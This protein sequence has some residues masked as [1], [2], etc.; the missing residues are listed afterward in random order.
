MLPWKPAPEGGHR[1]ADKEQTGATRG[2]RDEG[3]NGRRR[4][5][6]DQHHRSRLASVAQHG[7]RDSGD[8]GQHEH[9]QA[10][11][12][13]GVAVGQRNGAGPSAP[14][15]QANAHPANGAGAAA[16]TCARTFRGSLISGLRL[17]GA[18]SA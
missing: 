2:E 8:A 1:G 10:P 9:A 17:A 6:S 15:S 16:S 18:G 4:A 11:K 12:Y 3:D 7:Y 14:Y 5:E 13:L